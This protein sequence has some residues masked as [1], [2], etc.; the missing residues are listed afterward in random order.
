MKKKDEIINPNGKFKKKKA[1]MKKL[2]A[3]LSK[4]EIIDENTINKYNKQVNLDL[5]QNSS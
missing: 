3:S 1:I 4:S 5:E 2:R